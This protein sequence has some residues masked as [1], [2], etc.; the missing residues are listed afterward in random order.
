MGISGAE[1]LQHR[2]TPEEAD[3]QPELTHLHRL[4]G[5]EAWLR[6]VGVLSSTGFCALSYFPRKNLRG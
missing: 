3:L 5:H 1:I 2:A 6:G 4:F